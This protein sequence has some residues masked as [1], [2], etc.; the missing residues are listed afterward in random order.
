M[1]ILV[2]DSTVKY[3]S[4]LVVRTLKDALAVVGS[5][6]GLVFHKSKESSE[7][8]MRYITEL[9][10]KHT[11]CK[12]VYLCNKEKADNAFKMLVTGGLN[13]KYVD[14]EFYLE[15]DRELNNLVRDTGIV[16]Q[17]D[18]IAGIDVLKDF[19]DRYATSGA[20][21]IPKR[22]L[23]VVKSAAL[24]LSESYAEKNR[25]MIEMSESA[26]EI[27]SNSLSLISQ[28]REQQAV[29]EKDMR[30]LKD[31]RSEMS[32]MMQPVKVAGSS[33][34]FYPRVSYFKNKTIIRI[35]D[36]G[37]CPYLFSFCLGF[38]EYLESIKS[39]RPKLI[40]IEGNGKLIKERYTEYNWVTN[41]NKN[42]IR[43]YYEKVVITNCPTTIV[44]SRALDDN[45][46]DT[47][48]VLDRTE[49]YKDHVLNSKGLCVYA[50]ASER[51]IKDFKLNKKLCI[52]VAK[53]IKGVLGKVPYF[54]DYPKRDDQRVNIYLKE[55]AKGYNTLFTNRGGD[56]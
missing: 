45:D 54:E 1:N 53:N 34:L 44:M 24:E 29:L 4:W 48:I 39:V 16:V 7:E 47:F 28:L 27:F 50:V 20:K 21:S 49:N 41:E 25:E 30:K 6:E 11:S 46:Y 3:N 12:I 36:I 2:S 32:A 38:R 35:K 22:Y 40:V 17:S 51:Y 5:V 43:N 14:D 26:A 23:A 33:I 15:S 13:G 8:K 31:K 56:I 10:K 18:S 55:C 52:S 42:D 9:S 19:F 37:R